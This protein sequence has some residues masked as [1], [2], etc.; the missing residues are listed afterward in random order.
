MIKDIHI[1]NY[2]GITDLKINDCKRIN[3]LVGKNGVG[4]TAVLEWINEAYHQEYAPFFSSWRFY[5]VRQGSNIVLFDEIEN[6]LHFTIMKDFWTK[7]IA[8]VIENDLQVFA[9]T[10]SY[11][12]LEALIEAAKKINI[13]EKEE[14]RLYRLHKNEEGSGITQFDSWAIDA[15][16]EEKREVRGHTKATTDFNFNQLCKFLENEWEIR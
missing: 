7:L 9:T 14:L 8:S 6:G 10:H 2:C 1:Q 11:E 12:M 16:L 4:K 5:R 15:L 3:L 13:I